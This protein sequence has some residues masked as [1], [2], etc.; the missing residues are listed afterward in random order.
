MSVL[1]GS[2]LFLSVFLLE[3]ASCS[4]ILAVF[5]IPFRD[6]Q[7][8]FRPLI[9]DLAK[10]GH[11][12]TVLTTDPT[13]F[14]FANDDRIDLVDLSFAHNLKV[15]EKLQEYSGSGLDVIRNVFHV[16]R[17]VAEA[18]LKS[19]Q[20]QELLRDSSRTFDAVLIDWSG[21]SLMNAFA[22]KFQVPLIGITPGGALTTSHE[23]M[24]N[25]NHPTCFP[26]ILL[27]FS[28]NLSLFQRIAS[29][30]FSLKYRY[31]YF[32]EEL[33]TQNEIAKD[34]FGRDVPDLWDIESN[35][36]LLLINTYEALGNSRPV[37]RTTI[38]LGGIHATSERKT[39]PQDLKH[40]MD[41]SYS[42]IV[43]VNLDSATL[44]A[45]V[46][47]ERLEKFVNI[48]ENLNLDILWNLNELPFE[49][50]MTRR[51][52]QSAVI[53]Q[54]D[55]LAH[56]NTRLFIT[57]GSQRDIEDA[58][59][60]TVPVLGFSFSSTLEH[61]LLQIE[62]HNAGIVSHFDLESSIT[63]LSKMEEIAQND[64]YKLN[65]LRLNQL[66][67]DA[68]QIPRD[69]AVWWIEYVMRHRGTNHLRSP[70]DKLSWF[71]YLLMDVMLSIVLA[72]L[73]VITTIVVIVVKIRR[74]SKSL[75]VELVTRR[76]KMKLQ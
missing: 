76:A 28:D 45:F 36:D 56:P 67:T 53:P 50:N 48:L 11:E 74:Y 5:P 57:T 63:I 34:Y 59:H 70:W 30:F 52:Y 17:N 46:E 49:V 60:H 29:A 61:Y 66:V 23:A 58:I 73:S 72:T 22:W 1:Q 32:S 10:R 55:V 8:V 65:M 14:S 15:L 43:Y 40:F 75:P 51:L 35:A 21:P 6:H 69:R 16:T 47:T 19:P 68:P 54:E 38:F 24:G 9:Q 64:M 27:P 44:K 20:V 33:P 39:L 71:Q 4:R 7:T 62:K 2:V 25:P 37:G 13:S 3:F 18:E 31:L 26:S 12:L 42:G 41:E